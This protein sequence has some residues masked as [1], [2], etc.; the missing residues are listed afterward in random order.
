MTIAWRT[1]PSRAITPTARPTT[2]LGREEKRAPIFPGLAAVISAVVIQPDGK[3]ITVGYRNSESSDS[4]FLLASL[5]TNG[6][7]DRTFGVGGKVHASLGNLNDG[8]NR[9]LLQPDGK[10][11]AVGFHPTPSTTFSEFALARFHNGLD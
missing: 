2:P 1:L 11:V 4:D 7:L 9:A 5:N 6:K 10:I 3:I 8:A